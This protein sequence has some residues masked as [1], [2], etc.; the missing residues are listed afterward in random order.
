MT[1]EEKNRE[2]DRVNHTTENLKSVGQI[3]IGEL[4]S[5]GGI[6]TGD[7]LTREE[8]EFNVEVGNLHQES[9]KVLTAIDENE[10]DNQS[11]A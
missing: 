2:N 9:N 7:P 8:G 1:N 10:A 11:S 5:I 4:E 6:L 3:I